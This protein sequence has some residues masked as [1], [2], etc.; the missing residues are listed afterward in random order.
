MGGLTPTGLPMTLVSPA[1]CARLPT[2]ERMARRVSEQIDSCQNEQSLDRLCRCLQSLL[3]EISELESVE[4][5]SKADEIARRRDARRAGRV[6][7]RGAS[8]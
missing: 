6:K 8:A 1:D 2:L 5:A 4:M 3:A 7:G